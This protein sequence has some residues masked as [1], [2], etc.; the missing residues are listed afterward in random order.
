MPLLPQPCPQASLIEVISQQ[1][2]PSSQMISVCHL[3]VAVA[4]PS[5]VQPHKSP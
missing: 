5:V 1:E 2:I 4:D 3:E